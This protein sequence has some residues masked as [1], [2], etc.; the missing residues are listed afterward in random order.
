MI[1][2]EI[3][4]FIKLQMAKGMPL[5]VIKTHLRL[6]GGWSENDVNE[7][8]K[9]L[10]LG[11]SS[12]V[13]TALPTPS[14][15]TPLVS[16]PEQVAVNQPTALNAQPTSQ[17]PKRVK[18]ILFATLTVLVAL[19][20]VSGV[21][22]FMGGP[23]VEKRLE[24]MVT[25][26]PEINSFSYHVVIEGETSNPTPYSASSEDRKTIKGKIEVIG[27]V[28]TTD[29]NNPKLKFTFVGNTDEENDKVSFGLAFDTVSIGKVFYIRFMKFPEIGFLPFN[30]VENKWIKIEANEIVKQFGLDTVI[31]ELS[32]KS[33]EKE[34]S[35]EEK[36]EFLLKLKQSNFLVI[37]KKLGSQKI[38]DVNT[39]GYSFSVDKNK[40]LNFLIES[41]KMA[42]TSGDTLIASL[43]QNYEE[44]LNSVDLTGGEI[45]FGK[46]DSLPYRIK[47]T[48]HSKRD[49]QVGTEKNNIV[50][51]ATF[52]DYNQPVNIEVPPDSI[53]IMDLLGRVFEG[54]VESEGAQ[55]KTQ[56]NI[57]TQSSYLEST[58]ATR[59][60]V[61]IKSNISTIRPYM[62][63]YWDTHNGSYGSA[64]A[65]GNCNT[66]NTGFLDSKIKSLL[67]E[68]EGVV[69]SY[70]LGSVVCYNTSDSYAVS[71]P[72]ITTSQSSGYW[73]VDSTGASLQMSKHVSKNSCE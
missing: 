21:F 30:E 43:Q 57:Y 60:N 56:Q 25:S 73:C 65:K 20:A 72:L 5:N 14:P 36:D 40:L 37:N 38:G 58:R 44:T 15:I 3:L 61:S 13:S 17:N 22:A 1:N 34:F 71:A 4:D 6:T 52:N 64:S 9:T 41:E 42:Q 16:T 39:I 67:E 33:K 2:Q 32:S 47:I 7:A 53:N 49:E 45:W 29:I 8:F 69:K 63:L 59:A 18:K 23:S 46:G 12:F 28:D 48:V 35:Q 70:N 26:L 51:D 11:G 66:P 55:S 62:E 68:M 27:A 50:F 10:N 24:T 19:I 31:N 54:L